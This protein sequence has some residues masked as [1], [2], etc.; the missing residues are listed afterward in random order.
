MW[1]LMQKL[2]P[3]GD[4]RGRRSWKCLE[5]LGGLIEDPALLARD[6]VLIYASL[7]GRKWDCG[8]AMEDVRWH[9]R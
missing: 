4:G 8:I 9:V 7:V 6:G 2:K 3:E 1:T 5:L